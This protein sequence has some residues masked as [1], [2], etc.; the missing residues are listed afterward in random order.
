VA[1]HAGDALS[2]LL[3]GE[4]DV[5]EADAIRSHLMECA[6]CA[7]ELDGVRAA[8]R[9]LRSL[10]AVEPPAGFFAGLLAGDVV[11]P[12]GHARRGQSS[13]RASRFV[14]AGVTGSVAAGVLLLVIAASTL[15]MAPVEPE[16]D[17]SVERHASTVGALEASGQIARNGDRFVSRVSAP[18]TTAE[19]RSTDHLPAPYDA[20]ASVAGYRLVEAYRMSD[21]V[22]LMYRRGPYALSIFELPGEVDWTALPTDG[23]RLRIAGNDAWR[24]DEVTADGRLYV[25][26]DGGMVVVLIG[27][28]PGDAVLDVATELPQARSMPMASRVKRTVAKAL[29]LFSPAP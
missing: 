4:L 9:L 1:D 28:E 13:R 11:V 23:T 18:P 14:A 8:R 5:A 20:P 16:V 6:D 19:P 24:W 10:P 22:H 2:A 12:I 27:D 29:E 15:S 17:E 25:I 7:A 3:D 21:G 26:D